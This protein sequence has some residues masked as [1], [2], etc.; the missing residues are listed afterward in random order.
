MA[1]KVTIEDSG[2]VLVGHAASG[3][4]QAQVG[5]ALALA[6]QALNA[7]TASFQLFEDAGVSSNSTTTMQDKIVASPTLE[8]GTYEIT[9][10]FCYNSAYNNNDWVGDLLLDGTSLETSAFDYARMEVK[11]ALG[12]VAGTG[13]DQAYSFTR[14]DYVTFATNA[15]HTLQLQWRSSVSGQNASIWSAKVA[16]RK[17]S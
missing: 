8:A 10:S 12:D 16:V 1:D 9:C 5:Q 13:S 15:A 17:V 4:T 6:Q 3:A 7:T 2:L 11:D 14:V